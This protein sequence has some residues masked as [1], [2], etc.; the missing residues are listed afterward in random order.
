MRTIP[1]IETTGSPR[2]RGRQHGEA[3]REEIGRSLAYYREAF[4]VATGLDWAGVVAKARRWR[5]LVADVAPHLLEEVDG[6]AEGAGAGPDDILALNARGEIVRSYDSEFTDMADGCSSY[7]LMPEATADQHVYCGQNWDWRIGMADTTVLLRIVQPPKPTIIM[8]VEAGQVGR[9]G[10]NSAGI[11]L[12]GN[13]LD[14]KFGTPP[15]LPQPFLRRLILDSATYADALKT[16]FDVHQHI[17]TNLLITHRD[18]VAI[19]LETTPENHRWGYPES[20]VL[21]HVNH[22]QY[23]IP[24]AIERTYR[25]SSP[26]S[27]FRLPRLEAG[28]RAARDAAGADGVRKVVKDS[29][30]D[31]FGHPYGVCVH[32]DDRLDPVYRGETVMHSLVD[33]TAGEYRVIDGKPCE[34]DYR[35]LPWSLYDGPGSDV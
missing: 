31:H 14:G 34:G 26:D 11:A 10:A 21:V 19:D 8:Q 25:P 35:L 27:L 33:L 23:G 20:G 32:P 17:A 28:L 30:S 22:Y 12:N 29:M 15:G 6:I 2:E 7:A 4:G 18:G 16:P 13:G 24:P 1:L 5:P 3:A 9:H